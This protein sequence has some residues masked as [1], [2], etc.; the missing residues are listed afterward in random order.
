MN[1][2]EM[3]D[4][5]EDLEELNHG[6]KDDLDYNIDKADRLEDII[7]SLE[8]EVKDTGD[9]INNQFYDEMTESIY[10]VKNL[11]LKGF[12]KHITC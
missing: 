5:I 11:Q 2:A 1:K 9:L 8:Q 10:G 3:Q 6:L 7:E 4:R 12:F